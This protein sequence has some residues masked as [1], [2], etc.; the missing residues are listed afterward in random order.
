MLSTRHKRWQESY[1]K[2]VCNKDE[3][4]FW[5]F[6]QNNKNYECYQRSYSVHYYCWT[7]TCPPASQTCCFLY[8][9]IICLAASIGTT[10][11][12]TVIC[13][14][15]LLFIIESERCLSF[16]LRLQLV[17]MLVLHSYF[18]FNIFRLYAG[19]PNWNNNL[20]IHHKKSKHP[21]V[22]NSH[23]VHKRKLGIPWFLQLH[24]KSYQ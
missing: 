9:L 6:S 17:F 7:L 5:S 13:T 23:W 22:N 3:I 16:R 8:F 18:C 10:Q 11:E 24:V 12:L 2:A 14:C 4:P 21:S 20:E 19:C 1:P 15:M